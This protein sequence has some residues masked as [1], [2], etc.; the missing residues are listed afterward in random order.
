MSHV[1]ADELRAL[2]SSAWSGLDDTPMMPESNADPDYG[3]REHR[4]IAA[5][6]RTILA[7]LNENA[8]LLAALRELMEASGPATCAD[9]DG[10]ARLIR[11]YAKARALIARAEEG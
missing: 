11:A 8:E 3:G 5:A 1:V 6:P 4:M 9:L 2:W 7:L 10:T